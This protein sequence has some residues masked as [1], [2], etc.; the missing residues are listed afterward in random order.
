M[1]VCVCVCVC[2]RA[3]AHCDGGR[4]GGGRGQGQ[5]ICWA[6]VRALVCLCNCVAD[7]ERKDGQ[8]NAC[9]WTENIKLTISL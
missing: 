1:H 9:R 8:M 2:V 6:C 4:G 5:A 7:I 3:R